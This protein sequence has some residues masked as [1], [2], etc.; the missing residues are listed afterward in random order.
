[1]TA[2]SNGAERDNTT[3]SDLDSRIMTRDA[4]KALIPQAFD[5]D[6]GFSMEAI[7]LAIG[8][9][10]S[11]RDTRFGLFWPGK[12][13]ALK[14]TASPL[15]FSLGPDL[16]AS[17]DFHATKNVFIEAD[18]LVALRLMQNAYAC[19]VKLIYIDPPYNTGNDFVYKDDFKDPLNA[20][21]AQTGQLDEDGRRT[22]AGAMGDG[23]RRHGRWFDF[24]YPRLQL[25][26]R[27]LREDGMI[28]VSIDDHEQHHLRMLMDE[29][30][31]EENFIAQ[32]A[33]RRTE[34]QANIGSFARVKEYVLLYARSI[35]EAVIHRVALSNRAKAAYSY[36][37]STTG[38]KFRRGNLI[39]KTRGRY[40]YPYML[41]DGTNIDGPWMVP[42]DELL[43]LV[44]DNM[45]YESS[46]SVYKKK[47][48]DELEGQIPNDFWSS[49]V[50]SNQDGTDELTD[51]FAGNNPFSFPK[52]TSLIAQIV[53]IGAGDGDIVLDFFG[54]SGTTGHAVWLQNAR[55]GKNRHFVLATLPESVAKGSVA[56]KSGYSKISDI[57]IERLKRSME[58]VKADNPG[59]TGDAGF[60][61]FR[62]AE[63]KLAWRND[64]RTE[65]DLLSMLDEII[66]DTVS[67]KV[68]TH[69]VWREALKAGF[70]L[71]APITEPGPG[72][73]R[74]EEDERVTWIA[75]LRV[76]EIPVNAPMKLGGPL[77][78]KLLAAGATFGDEV[79]VIERNIDANDTINVSS[80]FRTTLVGLRSA[81]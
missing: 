63:E 38:K 66:A 20:Y 45:V 12:V 24:M 44:Q 15:P 46:G 22:S 32:I 9:E 23:G 5:S 49:D 75:L 40:S 7:R 70:R 76:R 2:T 69:L 61:V 74:A 17:R 41:A 8:E 47:F 62:L 28:A 29:V 48:L 54:G 36:T 11:V 52:P 21:L 64:I 56:E 81:Q 4:L 14:S 55:D 43:R 30:F 59:W 50:G 60:R 42:Q 79:I 3:S 13:E 6:G 39:E 10:P 51:I 33:W 67:N 31:G 26:R 1:M 27:L 53:S 72:I 25:A 77:R 34:N 57:T 73:Y 37:C 71:D 35:R 80:H 68:D 65:S 18:N 19:Q 78:L 58:K 16:A